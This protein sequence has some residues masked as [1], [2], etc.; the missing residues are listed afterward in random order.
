MAKRRD[1]KEERY[2]NALVGKQI[3]ILTLDHKW[4]QLF[5]QTGMPAEIET[6]SRRLNKLLMQQGKLG[7]EM[8]EIGSL[9]KKLM[10][11]IVVSM[12]PEGRSQMEDRKVEE[13]GRLLEECNEKLQDVREEYQAIPEKINAL[14]YELMLRTMRICYERLQKNEKVIEEISRWEEKIRIELKKQLIEK[15]ECKTSNHNLY[16]YMHDIFGAEV[17]E[18]FDMKY[19]YHGNEPDGQIKKD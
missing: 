17:I 7:T 6:L 3:P 19:V 2:K 10:N 5:A 8:K 14:N 11:N 18:I 4:H 12:N 13:S 16:T 15:Q 1:T 9:K